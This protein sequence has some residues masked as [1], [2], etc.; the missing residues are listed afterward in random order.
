L[1][2]LTLPKLSASHKLKQPPLRRRKKLLEKLR[3][4]KQKPRLLLHK[5]PLLRKKRHNG[6][7][8]PKQKPNVSCKSN[9]NKSSS[10]RLEL[11]SVKRAKRSASKKLLRRRWLLRLQLL[12]PRLLQPQ[13]HRH[14]P[15]SR[16][17]QSLP[18]PPMRS[19]HQKI[20]RLSLLLNLNRI[21]PVVLM[22]CDQLAKTSL[23]HR[24][25]RIRMKHH[26][27]QRQYC[28]PN[29]LH[30]RHTSPLRN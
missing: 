24:Y 3:L 22:R 29:L 27:Q 21:L 20:P 28:L 30:L 5:P 1:Q 7:P 9:N 17:N 4:L 18:P 8:K 11:H 12:K 25:R 2:R 26:Q 14:Y 10:A 16:R 23:Q 15:K 6:A 13:R 19:L